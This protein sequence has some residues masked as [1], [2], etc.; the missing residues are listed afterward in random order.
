MKHH[1]FREATNEEA[2]VNR[3]LF[4]QNNPNSLEWIE[5]LK[6][7]APWLREMMESFEQRI[8]R[9]GNLSDKQTNLLTSCYIDACMRSKEDVAEQIAVRKLMIR[10]LE[11]H[12]GKS[13]DFVQS[14]YWNSEKFPLSIRQINAVKNCGD[15]YKNQLGNIPEIEDNYWDGW[16]VKSN[17][18]SR[19]K[20]VDK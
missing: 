16:R 3:D 2:K 15:R 17:W 11:C 4:S 1:S 13:R 14:V 12:I 10:L 7:M 9:I 18:Y 6:T 5:E 20:D 8:N 19:N